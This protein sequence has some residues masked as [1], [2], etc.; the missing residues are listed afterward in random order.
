MGDSDNYMQAE[1]L[2]LKRNVVITGD[3]FEQYPCSDGDPSC[4]CRFGGLVS[5]FFL[6]VLSYLFFVKDMY[7]WVTYCSKWYQ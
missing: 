7:S 6:F 1:V 2:M 5:G 3:D 4:P